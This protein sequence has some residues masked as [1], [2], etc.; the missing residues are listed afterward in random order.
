VS[1][2]ITVLVMIQEGMM[3]NFDTRVYNISDFDEWNSNGLLEL[4]PEFQRRAVWSE[5]AKSYLIDTIIRG[6]PIPK[7]IM[8]QDL[9]KS[10]N[11]RV[12]VDGQ[13]R[14]RAVL[15]FIEGNFKISRAHNRDF[16]GYRFSDLP[17]DIKNDFMK[18]E[19]GVDILFDQT[20]E[21]I[22]DIFARVNTYSVKLNTQE[23]LN[24]QYLGF[25][26]QSAYRLG[27]KYVIYWI[28]SG[29]MTNSTVSRMAEAELASDLLVAMVGGVQSNK[30]I[31][32]YYKKFED[33]FNGLEE[34]EDKFDEVMSY[35]GEIYKPSVLK[36]N[37]FSRIQLFYSL[38]CSI[39]HALYGLKNME[40]VIRPP[41]TKASIGRIRNVLDEISVK[42]DEDYQSERYQAFIDASRRATTDTG[43]RIARSQ[44][45]CEEINEALVP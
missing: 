5:K 32:S 17:P 18:Y 21:E 9:R 16:A 25:F 26:K 37:N 19:I 7:L 1:P 38:F 30:S 12:V 44:F 40:A 13:Q 22:L 28:E 41:I 36:V 11:I 2:F 20:Y 33:D 43:R 31:S 3:K 24:A 27:Y 6:K 39:A 23:L 4:S 35:I 15:E 34:I 14:L 8:T 29:I 42:F 10:R 45:I